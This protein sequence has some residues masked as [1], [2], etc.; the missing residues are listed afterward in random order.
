MNGFQLALRAVGGKQKTLA[1][2]CGES[3]QTIC[4]WKKI[5]RIPVEKVRKVS[6]LTGVPIHLLDDR[7]APVKR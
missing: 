7:F 5:G 3:P 2:L 6:Q 1:D 4:Y